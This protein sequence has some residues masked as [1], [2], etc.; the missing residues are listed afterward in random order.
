V[1]LQ[2]AKAH[3]HCIDVVNHIPVYYIGRTAYGVIE[4]PDAV[5][6]YWRHSDC[7]GCSGREPWYCDGVVGVELL[8][9]GRDAVG[10]SSSCASTDMVNIGVASGM[11]EAQ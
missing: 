6:G 11:A 3:W 1:V 9:I 4:P 2:G 7:V 5:S 10:N 8:V